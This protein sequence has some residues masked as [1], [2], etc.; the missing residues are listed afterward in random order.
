MAIGIGMIVM[1]K[2][3][4]AS[5]VDHALLHELLERERYIQAYKKLKMN[6][7][8]VSSKALLPPVLVDKLL[9]F[10]FNKDNNNNHNLNVIISLFATEEN[11][12]L[13]IMH[14]GC[15]LPGCITKA[16]ECMTHAHRFQI[17][18]YFCRHMIRLHKIH[19]P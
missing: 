10:N 19:S 4:S 1:V 8:L 17:F 12:Q 13:Y 2:V 16:Q 11:L 3:A 7:D 15:R 14:C 9:D 5:N 6:R 18:P